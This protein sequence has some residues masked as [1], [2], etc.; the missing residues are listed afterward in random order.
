[1]E[2]SR[3]AVSIEFIAKPN[4]GNRV[5]S[6]LPAAINS[7]FDGVTGFSGC[8]I[9]ASAQEERL[10]TVLTFWQGDLAAKAIDDNA[11]WVCRLLEQYMD[12]KLRVQ[13]MRSHVAMV[14]APPAESFPAACTAR[15]A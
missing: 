4:Q 1:L 8:A 15:V 13:T 14:P 11:R 9:L 10:V 12:Q 5:R 2:H 3:T 7:T 6:L